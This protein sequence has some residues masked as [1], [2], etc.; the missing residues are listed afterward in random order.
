MKT[1][2][3]QETGLPI[4]FQ[5]D[6]LIL[7]SVFKIREM[8]KL[9]I[10]RLPDISEPHGTI[11]CSMQTGE[12]VNASEVAEPAG[13]GQTGVSVNPFGIFHNVL[14]SGPPAFLQKFRVVFEVREMLSLRVLPFLILLVAM[15]IGLLVLLVLYLTKPP[16]PLCT[17]T[18]CLALTHYITGNMNTSIDPCVDFYQYACG[19]FPRRYPIP[20][21]RTQTSVFSN[22][23]DS[24]HQKVISL[25][26]KPVRN[27][28]LNSYER[29]LKQF[30]SSC[31]DEYA[32]M[33]AGAKPFID[34]VIGPFGGNICYYMFNIS[35]NDNRV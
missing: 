33:S 12:V 13:N 4:N 22:M 20:A 34:K 30:F 24:N 2:L 14:P 31:I 26:L 25:L 17:T 7:Y 32:V 8:E 23:R 35:V 15:A 19:Q 9:Q 1:V 6:Y 3:K 28:G 10:D 18:S 27:N 29:K 16:P 11:R 21:A 5:F